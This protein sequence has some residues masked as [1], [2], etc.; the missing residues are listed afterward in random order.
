VEVGNRFYQKLNHLHIELPVL[1]QWDFKIIDL[2]SRG[3]VIKL[4]TEVGAKCLKISTVTPQQIF[5]LF[6]VTEHLSKQGLKRIPRFIRTKYGEPYLRTDRGFYWIS[7]WIEGRPVNIKDQNDM[8]K[9]ARKLAEFHR[10]SRGF[11][12]PGEGRES[13]TDNNWGQRFLGLASQLVDLKLKIK[14]PV[15][16][17]ESLRIMSE[18]AVCA[19][20]ILSGLDITQ[21]REQLKTELSFCHG[22]FNREHLILGNSREIYVTGIHHWIRDIRLRD[23]TDLLY[24]CGRESQWDRQFF[25]KIIT[26]YEQIF[27][28]L[29]QELYLLQGYLFFPFGYWDLLRELAQ[30]NAGGEETKVRLESYLQQEEEKGKCLIDLSISRRQV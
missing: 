22:A 6:L 19:A 8:V 26:N 29:P 14:G 25:H 23:L 21:L 27:P 12:L 10:A 9:S 15:F 1:E 28:L 24:I 2:E 13:F 18:R 16:F 30:K 20:K 3:K 17:K 11:Y 7:D 4:E 5:R